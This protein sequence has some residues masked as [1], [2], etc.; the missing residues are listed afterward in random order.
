M[1][2]SSWGFSRPRNAWAAELGG[3]RP[4]V[5]II[6]GI[7]HDSIITL[8]PQ[9]QMRCWWRCSQVAGIWLLC[10][11]ATC[12][13]SWQWASGGRAG[14]GH[15]KTGENLPEKHK[16]RKKTSSKS[17]DETSADKQNVFIILFISDRLCCSRRSSS[18]T[19]QLRIWQQEV[20]IFEIYFMW[21][22]GV[23]V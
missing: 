23:Q 21:F 4:S 20:L 10:G 17:A 13:W 9:V 7:K 14:S 2:G 5:F 16:R 1:L 8:E 19:A 6:C 12:R 3:K 22:T 11:V 18:T 15:R